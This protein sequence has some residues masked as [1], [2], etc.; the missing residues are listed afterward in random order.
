MSGIYI[1]EPNETG[2]PDWLKTLSKQRS[3]T[4]QTFRFD[5]SQ[6]RDEAGRWTSGGG[7]RAATVEGFDP[8]TA[9]EGARGDSRPVS[10]AE[11]QQIAASGQARLDAMGDPTPTTGLDENWDGIVER[12]HGEAMESWGGATIDAHTGEFLPQG[13]DRYALTVKPPGMQTVS[14]SEGASIDEFRAGMEQARERFRAVLER[15][16]HHLGV[17]HDDDL[18]R[19][20]IDPV[21][22]V[23]SLQE[24]HEIG[25]VTKAVGGA[26][27]FKSGDGFW[28]PHVRDEDMPV[29][30]SGMMFSVD[31]DADVKTHFKGPGEWLRQARKLQG[32]AD[33]GDLPAGDEKKPRR[34][35]SAD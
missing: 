1:D 18:N 19:I 15:P 27:H 9:A 4:V 33:G 25:A 5:P 11:F 35:R 31:S 2:G 20:D 7:S 10:A 12:A 24:V 8:I 30:A 32:Q 28:P 13:A 16:Q 17:F 6:P 14:V 23:D 3:G 26:Y 29:A 21:L 22:V 34:F